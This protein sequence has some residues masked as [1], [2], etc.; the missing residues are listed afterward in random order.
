MSGI[1]GD[2][3]RTRANFRASSNEEEGKNKYNAMM[4]LD[5]IPTELSCLLYR[6]SQ[7]FKFD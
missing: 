5:A 2:L 7:T 4:G 6:K 1:A 3:I